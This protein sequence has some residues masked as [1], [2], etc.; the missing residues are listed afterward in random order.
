MKSIISFT[1]ILLFALNA[2]AVN[3]NS[4]FTGC[5]VPTGNVYISGTVT[6][7]QTLHGVYGATCILINHNGVTCGTA[8]TNG[9][10]NYFFEPVF[11]SGT[12]FIT[13]SAKGY[14]QQTKSTP[15]ISENEIV[16]FQLIP[17]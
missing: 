1:F 7:S 10:G 12:Y 14:F 9:F 5:D 17:N 8:R 11:T 3:F 13:V 6:D 16:D 4:I 2:L 15:G